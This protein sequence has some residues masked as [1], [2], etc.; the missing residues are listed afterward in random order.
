MIAFN[1]RMFCDCFWSVHV[2]RLI[3]Y[4]IITK[5]VHTSP[6]TLAVWNIFLDFGVKWWFLLAVLIGIGSTKFE[7]CLIF[8]IAYLDE[9]KPSFSGGDISVRE[10][11]SWGGPP[12]RGGAPSWGGPV[13]LMKTNFDMKPWYDF[14]K[15]WC[16]NS[17]HVRLYD[18][19][20]RNFLGFFILVSYCLEVWGRLMSGAPAPL[21]SRFP[22]LI[23]KSSQNL[24]RTITI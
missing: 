5:P 20:E 19:I 16:V 21:M 10:T 15:F 1:Q 14:S 8:I 12:S 4:Q 9:F 23:W 3:A 22:G 6:Q 24:F 13:P 2:V 18:H 11:C 7:V 17:E